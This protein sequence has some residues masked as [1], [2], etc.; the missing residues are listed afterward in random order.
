MPTQW[1]LTPTSPLPSGT[2]P[3][4]LHALACRLLETPGSEHTAQ[5]KPFTA[6]LDEGRLLLSWLDEPTEPDLAAYL[7]APVRLGEHTLR[8]ALTERRAQPYTRMAATPPTPRARVEFTSPAYVNRAG[9]QIPLPDPELLLAGLARRWAAFSPQPLPPD[10]VTE[11]LE[12]VHLARHDI[13]TQPVGTGRHQRTGF[14]GHAVFG[15]PARASRAAQRAFAALWSFA[16]FAGVGAQTTHGLGHVRAHLHEQPARPRPE[17]S[18]GAVREKP[19]SPTSTTP[20]EQVR[21][22]SQNEAV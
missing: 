5:T 8:L 21:H 9:R 13:R 10:A 4:H 3:A 22:L 11:V 17:R 20:T 1:T 14:V 2:D 15:L 12:S 6:A 19:T 7:A 18:Q 16:A